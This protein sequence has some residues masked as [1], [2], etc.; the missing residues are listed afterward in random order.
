MKGYFEM[1]REAVEAETMLALGRSIAGKAIVA[2][3]A[4]LVAVM[5]KAEMREA[6]YVGPA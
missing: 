3:F 6:F 5:T 2:D 1:E 4:V